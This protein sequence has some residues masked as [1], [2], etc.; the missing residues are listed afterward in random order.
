MGSRV[1][2]RHEQDGQLGAISPWAGWAVRCHIAMSRMGS[3]V[4]YHHGQDGQLGAMSLWAEWAARCY[5]TM[6]R[7]GSSVPYHY[8][9]DGQ[10]G[11]ISP[12]AGWAVR[13]HIAMSRTDSSG[14]PGLF[15]QFW[16]TDMIFW[17]VCLGRCLGRSLC[18]GETVSCSIRKVCSMRRRLF[19]TRCEKPIL[20][21]RLGSR[22]YIEGSASR[23]AH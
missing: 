5:I 6:G 17:K 16:E 3:S 13:C 19:H 21:E 12:W 10:F 4:L 23:R 14:S 20:C 22:A 18:E 15:R 7:M 2:Y 1:P 11:A 9:Q 8:G